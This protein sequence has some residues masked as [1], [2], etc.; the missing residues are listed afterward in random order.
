MLITK[1]TRDEAYYWAAFHKEKKMHA[2]I[3]H[4]KDNLDLNNKIEEGISYEKP[5]D[6]NK[7]INNQKTLF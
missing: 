7:N 2:A 5:T 6:K 4:V 3:Q 1:N